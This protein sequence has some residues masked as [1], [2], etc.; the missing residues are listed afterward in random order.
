MRLLARPGSV[1]ML[2]CDPVE[3][4]VLYGFALGDPEA[5]I[6]HY[7]FVKK[8]LRKFGLFGQLVSA[9]GLDLTHASFSHWTRDMAL[10]MRKRAGPWFYDPYLQFPMDGET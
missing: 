4:D 3:T 6:L 7:A 8:T 2:A 10:V 5:D 9:L 1:L